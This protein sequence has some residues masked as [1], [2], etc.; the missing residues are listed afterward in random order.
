MPATTMILGA[1]SLDRDGPLPLHRQLFD[2]LRHAILTGRLRPGARLPSTR[3]LASDLGVARNTV[4]AAFE[5]LVA[6]GYLQA[7]VG[8]GTKVSAIAPDMLLNAGQASTDSATVS[9]TE[10][11]LSARGRLLAGT[12]RPIPDPQR[13]AFQPGLPAVE[14]FPFATWSRLLAR[15][16]RRPAPDLLGYT[17]LGGYAGL[18]QS[19]AEYLGA[20]RGVNCTPE[21][22]IVVAGAQGG[23]DLV[24]R[25]L[26]DPGDTVWME[27]PGYLGARGALL[28]AGAR[29]HPVA[30]DADGLDVARGE[31]EAPNARLAYVTPSYQYPLGVTMSLERR[32][33]LIE[34]AH[35]A[36]AWVIEDDYD[37]EYR[38]RGRP[39]SALQGLDSGER[40]IYVGSFAKT[41]FPALRLGYIVVPKGLANV[42]RRALRH[43]GQGAPLVLQ[44]TVADFISEGHYASHLRRMRT[45]YAERQRQFCTFLRARFGDVL[46]PGSS[47]A[48]MQI[49][50]YLPVGVDDADLARRAD[51]AGLSLAALSTHY[52]RDCP[53]PGLVL[54]YAGVPDADLR[55]GLDRLERILPASQ[56][57]RAAI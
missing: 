22:L 52:L 18:R 6:E 7:R 14:E 36:N 32:L 13:R 11:S 12:V 55:A 3:V 54:G 51:D 46:E 25:M 44:A 45:L 57:Q 10:L 56:R 16:S 37:S 29:L 26:L 24:A 15:H 43:T 9:P 39:L 1:L 40:V 48:G 20:A 34:W 27:E 31:Q 33:R 23:L 17:H 47:D 8:S 41:M 30:V 50:A 2:G 5:Q 35:R 53:R 49:T 38:Y 42:F 19:I 28:G 4:M 21:Q